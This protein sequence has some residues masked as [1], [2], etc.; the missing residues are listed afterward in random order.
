LAGK[1][2]KVH[3]HNDIYYTEAKID[4]KLSPLAPHISD[5]DIHVTAANKTNWTAAYTH[6]QTAHAPSNAEKNQN[7]FSK[8]TVDSTT[9]EAD[10]ATDTLTFVGT[11]VTITP[12]ATKDQVTFSVAD[13]T[14]SAK[15]VVQL[16]N[17]TSSTSTTTA[18]TPNSVK[19]AYDL[20]KSA[21]DALKDK[22][23]IDHSH[24]MGD[25]GIYV[26]NTEPTSAVVGDIWVDTANDPSF[27]VPNLPEVTSADNGKIL[28]VVNGRWQAV[29]LN[30]TADAN[31]VVSI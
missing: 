30:L 7:A 19:S 13:G 14:T 1:A 5:S 21:S 12:D 26:Q 20:A 4:E 3:D 22:S 18:A 6:S 31:G 25:L 17:S 16:T 9:I 29:T 23:D 10:T 27:I 28:M 8:I 15:G 11:N 24:D 2:D